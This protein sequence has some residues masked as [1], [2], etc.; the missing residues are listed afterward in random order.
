MVLIEESF[1]YDLLEKI[2]QQNLPLEERVRKVHT[3]AEGDP[4]MQDFLARHTLG[5]VP[6]V[7]EKCAIMVLEGDP[8]HSLKYV[9]HPVTHKPLDPYLQSVVLRGMKNQIALQGIPH[10][11]V[12]NF[13]FFYD[14]VPGLLGPFEF[15]YGPNLA[16]IYGGYRKNPEAVLE[17]IR[18]ADRTL[19]Q[20]HQRGILHRDV[21][22][23]NMVLADGAL[24]F[25]D[26][27][28]SANLTEDY[29]D[30]VSGRI[31]GTPGFFFPGADRSRDYFALGVSL[32]K[33]LFPQLS[34]KRLDFRCPPAM[35]IFEFENETAFALQQ[36]FGTEIGMY[37]STLMHREPE[38]K[39]RDLREVVRPGFVESGALSPSGLT[40]QVGNTVH[41]SVPSLVPSGEF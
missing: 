1:M 24:H 20:M 16:H 23:G 37:F 12:L 40:Y 32:A 39:Q 5:D 27:S 6:H 36:K 19:D 9:I 4:M 15:L 21:K 34:L 10:V 26:F 22:P 29:Y 2:M 31:F 3:L 35:D 14:G 8:I 13:P 7:D 30:S 28:T 33:I 11:Q 38:H 41:L 17:H 25:I 18:G